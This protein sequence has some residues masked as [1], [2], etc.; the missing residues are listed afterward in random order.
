MGSC[1]EAHETMSANDGRVL[2]EVIRCVGAQLLDSRLLA[3]FDGS[4]VRTYRYELNG[5]RC[6][7]KPCSPHDPRSSFPRPPHTA[8]CTLR[9][10][11]CARPDT[12]RASRIRV[13]SVFDLLYIVCIDRLQLLAQS[14]KIDKLNNLP[15][16]PSNLRETPFSTQSPF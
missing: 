4:T 10:P 13:P 12:T 6:E 8:R 15:T 11:A 7:A 1:K 3:E 14:F 16:W 2:E 9:G 5:G